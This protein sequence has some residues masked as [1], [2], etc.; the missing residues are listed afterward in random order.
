MKT[1]RGILKGARALVAKGWMQGSYETSIEARRC[2]CLVGAVMNVEPR[3]ARRQEVYE[4]LESIVRDGE[5]KEC[6]L[7][8]WNDKSGRTQAEVVA[9][10]DHALELLP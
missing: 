2:F 3:R 6:S 7:T 10:F 9:L 8:K 1:A 5:V 4:I